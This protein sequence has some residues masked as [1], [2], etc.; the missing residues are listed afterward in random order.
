[1]RM[2]P[3]VS[4]RTATC[5][6]L[7]ALCNDPPESSICHDPSIGLEIANATDAFAGPMIYL[8][9]TAYLRLTHSLPMAGL[10]PTHKRPIKYNEGQIYTIAPMVRR[11]R[12]AD[13]LFRA[14]KQKADRGYEGMTAFATIEEML[15]VAKEH[16]CGQQEDPH[17]R[18]TN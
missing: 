18:R 16:T 17:P 13:R 15:P 5:R 12:F 3:F 8:W 10:R 14:A 7:P 9:P 2:Q 4:R 6:L 1:M 11:D